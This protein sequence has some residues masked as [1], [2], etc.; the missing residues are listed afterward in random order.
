M[1]HH[2]VSQEE[3]EQVRIALRVAQPLETASPLIKATLAMIARC[4]RGRVPANLWQQHDQVMK[5]K[6]S[7]PQMQTPIDFKR[8]AAGDNE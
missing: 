4:W 2:H 6:T 1:T 8:R 5:G 3:M 7:R